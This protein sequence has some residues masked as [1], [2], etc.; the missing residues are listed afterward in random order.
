MNRDSQPD[1]MPEDDASWDGLKRERY[2]L[3]SA[4]L[5][6]EVTPTERAQV[7]A[8]LEHDQNMQ[9]L[10]AR[11][12]KLRR[13]LQGMPVPA[14]GQSVADI[15]AKVEA[16]TKRRPRRVTAAWGGVAIAALF[17]SAVMG[18]LTLPGAINKVDEVDETGINASEVSVE[19]DPSKALDGSVVPE[20]FEAT[21]DEAISAEELMIKISKPVVPMPIAVEEVEGSESASAFEADVN[22]D[23]EDL[24]D[25]ATQRA[26]D[27]TPTD[28]VDEALSGTD[29]EAPSQL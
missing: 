19:D 20:P 26:T 8:W 15:M 22:V 24:T 27:K 17:V 12:L 2:E 21:A 9:C 6:G 18:S 1:P 29:L 11:M 4:Y 16:Q 28:D 23:A 13:G 14:S 25:E 5:D 10:Y 3:L 7:L